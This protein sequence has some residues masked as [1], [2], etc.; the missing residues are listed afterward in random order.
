MLY[1][2]ITCNIKKHVIFSIYTV[3]LECILS[4]STNFFLKGY[5]FNYT[6]DQFQSRIYGCDVCFDELLVA[7]EA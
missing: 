6:Q 5:P 4:Q 2:T 3:K 7:F 1:I